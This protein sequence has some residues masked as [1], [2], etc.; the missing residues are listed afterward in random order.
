M[1][2]ANLLKV[3]GVVAMLI[4][5]TLVN[6]TTIFVDSNCT[7]E[8]ALNASQLDLTIGACQAGSGVDTIILPANGHYLVPI[9][10]NTKNDHQHNDSTSVK[11][12]VVIRG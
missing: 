10:E 4:V 9:Q 12:T 5:C 1:K 8:D 3:I 6:A 2:T 7:V 11:S